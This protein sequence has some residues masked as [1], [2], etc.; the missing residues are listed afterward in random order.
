MDAGWLNL[1][2]Q[3]IARIKG[4]P[5][6]REEWEAEYPELSPLDDDWVMLQ[7]WA[8]IVHE[9]G[10]VLA[11]LAV[12]PQTKAELMAD[13]RGVVNRAPAWLDAHLAGQKVMTLELF[14]HG[15]AQT[16]AKQRAAIER[17]TAEQVGDPT[18]IEE[19]L[20]RAPVPVGTEERSELFPAISAAMV[21]HLQALADL[22]YDLEV[23]SGWRPD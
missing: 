16:L 14:L 23:Q 20:E 17:V 18:S 4:A 13:M 9:Q 1:E 22:A 19:T 3:V 2:L 5:R 10:V 15:L 6:S 12:F 7:N 8:A 11:H 21:A